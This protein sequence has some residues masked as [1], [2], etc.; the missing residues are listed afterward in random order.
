[1]KD[2]TAG[3]LQ[4]F[5]CIMESPLSKPDF[6]AGKVFQSK[7]QGF[8]ID[9]GQLHVKARYLDTVSDLGDTASDMAELSMFDNVAKL[10]LRS[11]TIYKTGQDR[12]EVLWRT[13]LSDQSPR[14]YPLPPEFGRSFSAWLRY[15][16]A[17]DILRAPRQAQD[18]TSLTN[19]QPNVDIL[20]QADQTR[21]F[22]GYKRVCDEI[23]A[24]I[25][26]TV[27]GTA[28][29]Y[30]Y[31]KKLFGEM[32]LFLEAFRRVA[33]G[34]RIFRTEN[35]WLGLGPVSLEIGD[36]VWIL[37]AARTPFALQKLSDGTPDAYELVGEVYVH[38]AMHGETLG[39]GV[40]V[41][42]DIV[43]H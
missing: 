19:A 4:P 30:M 25:S 37:A 5:M 3:A 27:N 16:L 12:I 28:A 42:D 32:M 6:D 43:L 10:I 33:G 2:L 11:P 29:S 26:P 36:S 7:E 38:G 24:Y 34:R 21:L 39:D 22:S 13:L 14:Y 15:F 1:M 31:T 20:A 41:W 40:P 18:L 17:W 23:A 8:E 9:G 35:G